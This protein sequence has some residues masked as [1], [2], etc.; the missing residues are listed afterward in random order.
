MSVNNPAAANGL[1]M[2]L[3]SLDRLKGTSGTNPRAAVRETAKQLESLFMGELMKSMRASTMSSG[4]FENSGSEMA[5]GMLDTQFSGQMS[6]RPGGLA[7]AIAKQLERQMGLKPETADKP[8]ATGGTTASASTLSRATSANSFKGLGQ[9]GDLGNL[10]SSQFPGGNGADLSEIMRRAQ[11]LDR[12]NARTGQANAT[13]STDTTDAKRLSNSEQFIRKHHDAAKAAEAASGIPS[14]HILGQAALESGWGKHEIKMK[15][16][17]SSHNL[18][19]IKATSDWKGKVAEVTTTEYMG[20]VARKVTAKF[21]AYDS[22]A[23]AFKDHARLLTQSPRYSQTVA[24]A[25][26]AQGYAQ[27]LQ[28]AGYATDPAYA[29]KLTQVINTALRVQRSMA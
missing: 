3:R 25:D 18:F 26:T 14:G 22:Y 2:D 17:T 6:G 20:G 16:G 27:G 24:K 23:D 5:T 1:S 7:D 12:G 10:D 29:N 4:M 28:K 21:R 13:R 11:S 15:D 9:L 8:G 19:G